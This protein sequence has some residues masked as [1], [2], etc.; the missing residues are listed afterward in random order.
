MFELNLNDTTVTIKAW[1]DTDTNE[2]YASK[3]INGHIVALVGDFK[4]E[5]EARKAVAE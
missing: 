5:A 4:T 3:A 1:L 2:W